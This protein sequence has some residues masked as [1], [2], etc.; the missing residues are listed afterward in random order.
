MYLMCGTQLLECSDNI[1]PQPPNLSFVHPKK[2][3]FIP[4][5]RE[6]NTKALTTWYDKISV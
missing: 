5:A 3:S 6:Q 2:T 4:D 1:D